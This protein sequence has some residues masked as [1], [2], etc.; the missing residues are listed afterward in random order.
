MSQAEPSLAGAERI[1]AIDDADGTFKAFD[2]YPWTKDKNFLSGL[3][4]ILGDPNTSN[5]RGEP[6]ELALHARIFYYAQ[7]VGVRIDFAQYKTWLEDHPK[8]T[9]PDILPEEY[10]HQATTASHSTSVTAKGDAPAGPAAEPSGVPAWQS[11]APKADLY[12]D[13]S[14]PTAAPAAQSGS[15]DQPAY[16]MGFAEMLQRI[17]QGLPIPGIV[18]IPD[19]VVRDPAVKPFGAR[20]APKKPWEKNLDPAP[21]AEGAPAVVDASF[22]PLDA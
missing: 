21:A 8:H 20:A 22:P 14:Q 17:Q 9:P 3:S 10:A 12:V 13:K 11:S 2:T 19:T 6:A 7:R 15:A 4:A 16:P 5:P 1:R 18:E